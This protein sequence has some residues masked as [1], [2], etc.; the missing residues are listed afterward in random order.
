MLTTR[1]YLL[2]LATLVSLAI[3]Y[4]FAFALPQQNRMRLEAERQKFESEQAQRDE[5]QS[6][7]SAQLLYEQHLRKERAESLMACRNEAIARADF[8]L[9]QNGTPVYGE[10]GVYRA[11]QRVHDKVDEMRRAGIDE[12]VKLYGN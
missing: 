8:H 12:C 5:D 1:N 11:S 7:A 3:V 2:V 4:Y 9:E 10:P 6:R